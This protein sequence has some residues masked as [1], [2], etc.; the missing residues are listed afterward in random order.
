MLLMAE[1]KGNPMASTP[2][3]ADEMNSINDL[4]EVADRFRDRD[5]YEVEIL[6]DVAIDAWR[7]AGSPR[8]PDVPSA[9]KDDRW[10]R[11]IP[12]LMR[13]V[14]EVESKEGDQEGAS[15]R[16]AAK[17]AARRGD[18]DE[19]EKALGLEKVP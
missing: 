17:R 10:K 7:A 4:L 13:E 2:M 14:I 9:T 8:V 5:S 12:I 15:R 16:V 18:I 11:A 6:M 1:K 19:L 3:K